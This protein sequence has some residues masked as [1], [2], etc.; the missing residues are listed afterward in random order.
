M[1][2]GC[3]ALYDYSALIDIDINYYENLFTAI[4]AK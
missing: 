2:V 3:A 1:S 4:A